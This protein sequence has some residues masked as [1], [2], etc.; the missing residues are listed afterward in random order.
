VIAVIVPTNVRIYEDCRPPLII[1]RPYSPLVRRALA[2][3]K[4][5]DV[6][7][8]SERMRARVEAARALRGRP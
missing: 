2:S 7:A 3:V 8:F 5:D 4:T 1:G 6:D